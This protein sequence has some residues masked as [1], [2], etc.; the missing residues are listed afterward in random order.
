MKIC[1]SRFGFIGI[2]AQDF[3]FWKDKTIIGW[4]TTIKMIRNIF[5][6]ILLAISLVPIPLTQTQFVNASSK[7]PYDSGY[8]HGC[9]DVDISDLGD[10]YI[11][12]PDKGPSHHTNEFMSGY[13]DGYDNC[14]ERFR[15]NDDEERPERTE[16]Q[17]EAAEDKGIGCQPEDDYCDYDENCDWTSVDC[18]DDRGF[19]EDDYNG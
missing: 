16:E 14:S 19:D 18:I 4:F 1:L 3:Q 11:N 17:K 13:N 15:D 6:I 7:S 8:D 12:Q 10:R 2:V 5:F 9:D